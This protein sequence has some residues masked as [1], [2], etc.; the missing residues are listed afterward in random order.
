[1]RKITYCI[2]GLAVLM[3]L[4]GG[5]PLQAQ[6]HNI[7][8]QGNI[9]KDSYLATVESYFRVTKFQVAKCVTQGVYDDDIPIVLFIAQRTGLEPDAV[10]SVHT[11]GLNWTQTAWHFKLNPLVFYTPLSKKDLEHSAYEKTYRYYWDHSAKVN[12]TDSEIS[13][14]VNLKFI[15][16]QYGCPPAEVVQARTSGKTFR[17]INDQYWNRKDLPVWDVT[18]PGMDPTP[19]PEPGSTGKHRGHHRG[20]GMGGGSSQTPPGNGN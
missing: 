2:L 3:T 18:I 5:F 4:G 12:L 14:L 13:D 16:E 19:T 20:G 15:T 10:L 7:G 8:I 17:D 1:M 9:D 6:Q 11:S